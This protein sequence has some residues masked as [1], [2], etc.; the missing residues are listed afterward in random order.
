MYK[1]QKLALVRS[2]GET[3]KADGHLLIGYDDIYSIQYFGDNLR[4]YWNREGDVYKRQLYGQSAIQEKQTRRSTHIRTKMY[5]Q[6][7]KDLIIH[8]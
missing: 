4:P 5:G 3:Q 2:L 6:L 1:R 7:M 8:Y